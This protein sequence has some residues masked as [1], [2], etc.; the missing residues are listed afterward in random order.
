[1]SKQDGLG[2]SRSY[3]QLTYTPWRNAV[4]IPWLGCATWTHEFIKTSTLSGLPLFFLL[5][6]L[7]LRVFSS[8]LPKIHPLIHFPLTALLPPTLEHPPPPTRDSAKWSKSFEGQWLQFCSF[9]HFPLPIFPFRFTFI[10]FLVSLFHLSPLYFMSNPLS[11]IP[12]PARNKWAL[13]AH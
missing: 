8:F 7:H 9:Y 12:G 10:Y 13:R 6:P 4:R 5:I 2:L 11:F 3:K 1:M